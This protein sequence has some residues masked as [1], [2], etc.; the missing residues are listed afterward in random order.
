MFSV[1]SILA[2]PDLDGLAVVQ[3]AGLERDVNCITV[4]DA[5]YGHE[6]L[7]GGEFV[8]TSCYAVQTGVVTA[9]GWLRILAGRG[10]AGVGLIDRFVPMLSDEALDLARQLQ[11]PILAL[12][13][14]MTYS[15]IMRA[16]YAAL[17]LERSPA[18]GDGQGDPQRLARMNAIQNLFGSN[19]R[20][21]AQ[22]IDLA[23]L[24]GIELRLPLIV[25][26]GRVDPGAE[27]LAPGWRLP[28]LVD[29]AAEAAGLRLLAENTRGDTVVLLPCDARP[30]AEAM[31]LHAAVAREIRPLTACFGIS[32]PCHRWEDLNRSLDEAVSALRI[33]RRLYGANKVVHYDDLG[34]F[35]L[36]A[37]I[38]GEEELR[39]FRDETLGPLA[40]VPEDSPLR[41][42]KATLATYLRSNRSLR[43]A[44]RRLYV[45]QNTVAYRLRK[46]ERLT[47]ASLADPRS[48]LSLHLALEI[49]EVL[50]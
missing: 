4:Q 47:R 10:V 31:R 28:P 8:L 39:R 32:R 36:I 20:D 11:I 14:T 15:Q 2:L 16:V 50:G 3:P 38:D 6:W 37:K 45:H 34:V 12:P 42:L 44:A 22:A 41:A 23:L 9:E 19:A 29:R 1:R 5:P 25:L 24:V 18:V 49:D 48:A 30:D 26:A 35:R 46:A 7:R 27:P 17:A 40:T 33:G 13:G 21:R 43:E